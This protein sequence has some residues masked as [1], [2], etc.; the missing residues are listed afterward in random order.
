MQADGPT[1]FELAE[2]CFGPVSGADLA[3]Y[4]YF[5]APNIP[6]RKLVNAVETYARLDFTTE[7]PVVLYD[8]TVFG[9]GKRGF[10]VTTR[11]VHYHLTSPLD[12]L[13]AVRGRLP[14]G[15]VKEIR[16]VGES[17]YVNGERLGAAA[18]QAEASVLAV[19]RFFAAVV[20]HQRPAANQAQDI[21]ATIQRLKELVDLGAITGAEFEKKKQELLARL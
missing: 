1:I 20:E 19:E 2:R 9:S 6:E 4:G 10:L 21:L 3:V 14:L 16:F 11:Y 17:L 12:G 5:L 7:A 13:S 15:A 18:A 8:A